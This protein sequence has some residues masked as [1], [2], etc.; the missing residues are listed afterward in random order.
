MK[1]AEKLKIVLK[2]ALSLELGRIATDKGE[3]VYDGELAVGTEVFVEDE[4]GEMVPA[5]DGTYVAESK[6][7]VVKDGKVAEINE[8]PEDD[9]Q[10]EEETP[11][12]EPAEEEPQEEVLA[13][14]IEEPAAEPADA[15]EEQ[16]NETIEEKV[17]RLESIVNG[18]ADAVEQIINAV[19]VLENRIA[20]VENKIQDLDGTPAAEPAE[21]VEAEEEKPKSRLTYLRK[22]K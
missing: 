9:K 22:Q 7:I 10:P 19:A 15:P 4:N 16:E 20:A 5:P 11:A 18:F 2:R 12:E 17:A 1:I 13:D 8:I 3:L 21:E 14:E 6:E